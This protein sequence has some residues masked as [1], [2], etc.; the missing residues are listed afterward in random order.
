MYIPFSVGAG[1]FASLNMLGSVQCWYISRRSIVLATGIV[2]TMLGATAALVYPYDVKLANVY[3][4]VASLAAAGQFT[5]HGLRSSGI[6]QLKAT[7]I[8]YWSWVVALVTYS[9][10]RAQWVYALRYD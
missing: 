3:A 1:V 4:G 9:V 10:Y 7:S 2:N 5:L 8:L 6:M